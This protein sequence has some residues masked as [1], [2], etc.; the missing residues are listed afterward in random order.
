MIKAIFSFVIILSFLLSFAHAQPPAS[1]SP[2]PSAATTQQSRSG[3]D[4]QDVIRITTNLV[5]VDAVVTKDGKQVTDLKPEDFELF[6]D[7]HPQT[8]TN[9]SY[10]SNVPGSAPS[11]NVSAKSAGRDAAVVPIVPAVAHPH[12]ARRTIALV[13]DDLGMSFQSMN[14]VRRQVL[15]FINEKLQANDLVAIIRTGGDVGALQQFTTDRRMLYSAIEHLRWNPCS[16]TGL[17]VFAPAGSESP[18]FDAPCGGQRNLS[19]TLRALKFIVQGLHDLPGRKS[20]VLFSDHLPIEQQEPSTLSQQSQNSDNSADTGDADVDTDNRSSLAQLQKVAELAIRASVVL[21]AVD[22]RGLPYTGLTAADRLSPGTGAPGTN[23]QIQTIM[24][25]RSR[26]VFAGREGSD[27]I[28]RE[29]GGFLVRNSNDFGLEKIADDQKGYYLL[30]Y[31]PTE[32]TFNR[33]FHHLKVSL[34]RR[35]YTVRTRIGFYGVSEEEAAATRE[36]TPGDLL[37]KALMSPFGANDIAL[38]LTPLFA[39]FDE[40]GSLLR[41]LIYISANDLTFIDEPDGGRKATFDLGI[42]LFGD[43]GRIRE[44]Q[45]RTVTLRLHREDYERAVRN[46]IVYTLDTPLKQPGAFQFRIALR[47]QNSARIGSAGQFLQIPNLQ[48]GRLALSGLV[49]LASTRDKTGSPSTS[50]PAPGA[51][52]PRTQDDDIGSGPAVRRFREGSKILFV[53]STY[54]AQL[55]QAHLPQLSAQVRIFREGKLVFTGNPMPIDATG[56]P[57]LKRIANI[58]RLQLGPEFS[59][60]EYVLQVVVTDH[61]A[62][63]KQQTATQWID[64]EVIK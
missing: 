53:Y 42:I 27:L 8:I 54:N 50:V 57:D 30:G 31:R 35:G 7:S 5:Q 11:V 9:F 62:S 23:N 46:G 52:Q 19:G 1:Q 37:N 24:S 36:L 61:L 45:G 2:Q 6:E 60:G 12:D 18:P 41:S 4:D 34:K 63:E 64:F 38:R 40:T 44:Q 32:E 49:L 33:K 55:D 43:N 14:D 56:Q 47:D 58:T 29:T 51:E 17:Y 13:V 10:V 25:N 20:L 28:A 39:N 3:T 22:T 48:N 21:Y 26:A 59:P 16:R 15:K